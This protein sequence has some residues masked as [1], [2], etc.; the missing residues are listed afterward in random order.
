M[1]LGHDLHP[2]HTW[3]CRTGVASAQQTEHWSYGV[4]CCPRRPL[5]WF[6][7]VSSDS[8]AHG[9]PASLFV[10]M[11]GSTLFLPW[12]EFSPASMLCMYSYGAFV[13]KGLKIHLDHVI[14][15]KELSKKLAEFKLQG[16]FQTNA[17]YW[18][19]YSK[20][21]REEC[22]GSMG[23]ALVWFQYVVTRATFDNM[24]KYLMPKREL[25]KKE[26]SYSCYCIPSC[27]EAKIP[28]AF[29][30]FAIISSQLRCGWYAN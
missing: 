23:Q 8:N 13:L 30:G 9:S 29:I 4:R 26:L 12:V 21:Y 1:E 24:S 15:F 19:W 11:T 18:N 2:S 6:S 16:Q 3:V 17:C 28:K 20:R 10:L 27:R 14:H 25:G 22:L 7:M 5:L